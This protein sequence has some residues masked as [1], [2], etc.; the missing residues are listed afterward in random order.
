MNDTS[1]VHLLAAL[2]TTLPEPGTPL[3]EERR[4]RWLQAAQHIL[5]LLYDDPGSEDSATPAEG[6]PETESR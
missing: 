2:V 6:F 5:E 1:P 4:A 3:S